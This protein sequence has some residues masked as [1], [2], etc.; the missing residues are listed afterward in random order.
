MK[1]KRIYILA[2]N[3]RFNYGDLI[4]P[5]ILKHYLSDITEDLVFCSTSRSDLSTK[6]GLKT[7]SYTTLYK[8]DYNH[9]NHLIIAGG[10]SL[11]ANWN[12][13][14]SYSVK[15]ASQ[16]QYQ[17]N[18]VYYHTRLL[19]K[20]S[21]YTRDKIIDYVFKQVFHFKT[22]YPFT[23]GKHELPNLSSLYY[24][25]V[26]NVNLLK[27]KRNYS[28]TNRK[29]L[30]DSDYISVRD[31]STSEYL[32]KLGINHTVAPDCA[33]LM[34][35]VFTE[36][37]LFSKIRAEI[38]NMYKERKYI[39]FQINDVVW[40]QNK[41][42]IIQQLSSIID[43][44][45]YTICLC[46]IGTAMGHCDDIALSEIYNNINNNQAAIVEEPTLWE[47]MWLI[48]NA[49]LYIGTSLHG[50]ITSLSFGTKYI[51]HS[52]GKV[53]AYLKRWTKDADE[54][55]CKIDNLAD[56]SLLL[57][58]S[59]DVPNSNNQKSQAKQSIKA[60]HDGILSA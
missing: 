20:M 38:S 59:H 3:D 21:E 29:I 31:N 9:E 1:D 36:D 5:Y 4:F 53:E 6:G 32:Q 18:R 49:Q 45:N 13:I 17:L 24:N 37:F 28:E 27:D 33:I 47:I 7:E 52:V 58:S 26:G 60:I 44:A 10:E 35:E 57:L 55:F 54:H 46:P 34:S 22:K 19:T 11:F 39:F 16:I 2:P 30:S 56:V 23:I 42:A 8:M 50:V 25:S 40:S 43:K 48:K 14:L 51:S 41:V 15:K 12:V